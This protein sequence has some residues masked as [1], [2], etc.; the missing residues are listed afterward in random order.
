MSAITGLPS[1][2]MKVPHAVAMAF[3]FFDEGI[4]GIAVGQGAAGDGGGGTDVAQAYVRS[5]ARAEL[6]VGIQGVL[7][8][9]NGAA[10]GD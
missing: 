7:P 1:P 6:R 8:V 3:A 2:T 9:Y 10:C 4:T 5:S